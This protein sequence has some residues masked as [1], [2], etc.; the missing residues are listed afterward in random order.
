[1]KIKKKR[2]IKILRNKIFINEQGIM[3][4]EQFRMIFFLMSENL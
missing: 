1:M 3:N 4:N 2:K